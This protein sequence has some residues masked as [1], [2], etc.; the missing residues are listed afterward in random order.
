MPK[1]ATAETTLRIDTSEVDVTSWG[2]E[3]DPAWRYLDAAGHGHFYEPGYPTLREITQLVADE[4]GEEWQ[5]HVRWECPHCGEHIVPGTR[6]SFGRSTI[7]GSKRYFVNENEVD[8]GT[9]IA[10]WR[11]HTDQRLAEQEA[12]L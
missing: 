9:F 7:P 12:A 2:R 10:A 1:M 3:H 5:E 4:W 8:R 6:S 11:S